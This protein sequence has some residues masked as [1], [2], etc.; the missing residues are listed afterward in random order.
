MCMAALHSKYM[1]ALHSKCMAAL[2]SKS[3]ALHAVIAQIDWWNWLLVAETTE[4]LGT[5]GFGS[6]EMG[7]TSAEGQ[8]LEDF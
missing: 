3:I 1:A 8:K 2:H 7:L 6:F 5:V 4:I